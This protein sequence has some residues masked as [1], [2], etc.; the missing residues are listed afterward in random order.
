MNNRSTGASSTVLLLGCALLVTLFAK[1]LT[2]AETLSPGIECPSQYLP[3]L[4]TEFIAGPG[5]AS[6]PALIRRMVWPVC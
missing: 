6:R 5:V 4:D 3:R 2:A 1:D